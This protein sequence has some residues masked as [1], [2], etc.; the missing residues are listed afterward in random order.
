MINSEEK[1]LPF[2]F[3]YYCRQLNMK[4]WKISKELNDRW[5]KKVYLSTNGC[6]NL[7]G[8]TSP[9]NAAS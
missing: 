3:D 7:G 2:A 5:I 4:A 1:L 6:S 8:T 9:N